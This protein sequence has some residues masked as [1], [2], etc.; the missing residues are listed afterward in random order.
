MFFF[1]IFR[2]SKIPL[3]KCFPALTSWENH[4]WCGETV[5][6]SKVRKFNSRKYASV[7]SRCNLL[8]G[9]IIRVLFLQL[10]NVCVENATVEGVSSFMYAMGDTRPKEMF[11]EYQSSDLLECKVTKYEI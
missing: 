4:S 9:V 8:C 6:V 3:G 1:Q 2:A 10:N 11:R 5:G 7:T